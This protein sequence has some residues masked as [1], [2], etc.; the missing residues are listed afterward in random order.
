MGA[1]LAARA[2]PAVEPD[3]AA[4]LLTPVGALRQALIYQM[5]LDGI[6]R[7]ERIYHE[8]DPQIWLERAVALAGP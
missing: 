1:P 4:A 5:F 3:R 2:R 6:E 7:D 8:R